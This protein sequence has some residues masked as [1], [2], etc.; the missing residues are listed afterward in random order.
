M[1]LGFWKGMGKGLS[2]GLGTL[3]GGAAAIVNLLT[4][5]DMETGDPPSNWN[6][7]NATLSSVA[8]ARPGSSGTK[9]LQIV[10]S[11]AAAGLAQQVVTAAIGRTLTVKAWVKR[12]DTNPIVRI[13]DSS[14]VLNMV[15]SASTSWTLVEVSAV[16]VGTNPTVRLQNTN[17]TNGLSSRHDDVIAYISG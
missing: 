12:I 4:N 11:M 15:S 16:I 5:G 1:K 17:A 9:C 3:G 2:L 7:T 8:D 6:N 14:G 10:N 13:V